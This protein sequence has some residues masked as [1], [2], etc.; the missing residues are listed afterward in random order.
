MSEKKAKIPLSG[1]IKI[2]E[3]LDREI[4]IEAARLGVFKYELI[5]AAWE[6][7]KK[8]LIISDNRRLPPNEGIT[9]E[10][11]ESLHSGATTGK[12]DTKIP[13]DELHYQQYAASS[14]G[15][16]AHIPISAEY[17][18]WIARLLNILRNG[19]FSTIEA[20]TRNLDRFDLLTRVVNREAEADAQLD[21]LAEEIAAD[22][23]RRVE[24][25]RQLDA[26]YCADRKGPAKAP[27][28]TPSKDRRNLRKTSG[29]R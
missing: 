23:A 4:D 18:L 19:D 14:T 10:P 1:N 3:S 28:G 24:F 25:L 6:S 21:R 7:Y 15:G 29:G 16:K 8:G 13:T 12:V 27:P 2:P 22:P 26:R 9:E 11:G 20:I 5:L 17:A